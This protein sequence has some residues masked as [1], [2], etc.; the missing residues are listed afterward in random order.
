MLL[1]RS[2]FVDDGWFELVDD[3]L[4]GRRRQ[5]HRRR[6]HEALD[7][8]ELEA[9]LAGLVG[10][11]LDVDDDDLAGRE[12]LIQDLLRQGVL[13]VALDR[14]AQRTATELRVVPE[15]GELL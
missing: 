6:R 2:G 9:L 1:P 13:D 5:L 14:P 7:G 8:R 15:R 3:R 12:L 11:G 10:I 4:G